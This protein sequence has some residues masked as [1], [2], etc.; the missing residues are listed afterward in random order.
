MENLKVIQIIEHMETEEEIKQ[1]G[2]TIIYEDLALIINNEVFNPYTIQPFFEE[3]DKHNAPHPEYKILRNPDEFDLT[4]FGY[5]HQ[6][7][8]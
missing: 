7:L 8:N 2:S 6:F 5:D 4:E 1:F 3:Y